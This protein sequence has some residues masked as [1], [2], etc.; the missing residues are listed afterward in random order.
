MTQENSEPLNAYLGRFKEIL[1]K[2]TITDEAAVAAFRKGLLQG[3]QLRKDLAI[4]EPLDL[5]DALHRA[6]RYAFLEEEDA[7]LAGKS[8]PP[9]VKDKA[10]EVYQEPRQHCDPKATKRGTVFTMMDVDDQPQ[11]PAKPVNSKNFYCRFHQF[12]GHST[13][14]CKHLLNILLGKYKSREV[15]AIYYPKNGKNK[16]KGDFKQTRDDHANEGQQLLEH[17]PNLTRKRSG[18][19]RTNSR[20]LQKDGEDSNHSKPQI[21]LVEEFP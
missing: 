7:K 12:G 8:Q 13:E 14:E 16:R 3:S 20:G 2:V 4:R 11:Q 21:T 9:K 6:S 10:R 1:S 19:R 5:D 18:F 17:H 15:K